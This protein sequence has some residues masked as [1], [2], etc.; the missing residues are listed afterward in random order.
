MTADQRV[1]IS[2]D[3]RKNIM[4]ESNTNGNGTEVTT[5]SAVRPTIHLVL[6]GKSAVASW[7]AKFLI[8]SGTNA[9]LPFWT[10]IAELDVISIL[11]GAWAA[12]STCIC[13]SAENVRLLLASVD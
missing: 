3:E 11:Q 8:S 1:E 9:F 12:E 2:F 13:G 10:N 6:Q 7:L 4:A 5:V